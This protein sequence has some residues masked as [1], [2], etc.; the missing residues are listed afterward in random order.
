MTKA[1]RTKADES[2]G[3]YLDPKFLNTN[4]AKL[5]ELIQRDHQLTSAACI[6]ERLAVAFAEKADVELRGIAGQFDDETGD[7]AVYCLTT[8][9][10]S[11]TVRLQLV[12]S[13]LMRL[14]VAAEP[15]ATK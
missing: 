5:A 11:L 10:T 2:G 14:C 1:K 7:A 15:L 13:A 8:A 12:E 3:A 9:R 6:G 4:A